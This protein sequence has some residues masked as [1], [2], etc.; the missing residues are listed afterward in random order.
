MMTASDTVVR[1]T[2]ASVAAAPTF[3]NRAVSG[4]SKVNQ[5]TLTIAY[6]PGTMQSVS[7]QT[8]KIARSGCW[9]S[10]H[11]MTSPTIRP[12]QAP[13]TREGM[14]IPAK[15]RISILCSFVENQ[16]ADLVA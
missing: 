11:S 6:K 12:K 13:T 1:V 7:R 9:Y 8:S 5:V 2:P 16:L 14:N 4:L 15:L 10:I 3:V